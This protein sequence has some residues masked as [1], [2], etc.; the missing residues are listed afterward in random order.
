[1]LKQIVRATA[2]VAFAAMPLLAQDDT[3]PTVAVLPFVNSAIAHGEAP[4][5]DG[6]DD[7]SQ[8]GANPDPDN[9]G[10]PGDNDVPTPVSFQAVDP[11]AVPG[12]GLASLLMLAALL[13]GVASRRRTH[14]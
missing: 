10:D 5:G 11:I 1:M 3:R 2:V 13:A 6:V 9:N 8:D 4:D 14:S 12:L 7:T